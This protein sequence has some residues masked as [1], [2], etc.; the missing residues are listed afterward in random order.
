M[1]EGMDVRHPL[2]V[3]FVIVIACGSAAARHIG[4][5]QC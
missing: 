1:Q 4:G 3:L 2:W 5:M